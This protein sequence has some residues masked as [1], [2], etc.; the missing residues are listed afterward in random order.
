MKTI[1]IIVVDI[2]NAILNEHMEEEEEEEEDRRNASCDCNLQGYSRSSWN[3]WLH[4]LASSSCDCKGYKR[5]CHYQA[6]GAGHWELVSEIVWVEYFAFW[7]YKSLLVFYF[8][9]QTFLFCFFFGLTLLFIMANIHPFYHFLWFLFRKFC[10]GWS[11]VGVGLSNSCLFFLYI[12]LEPEIMKINQKYAIL[13]QPFVSIL[14]IF[15]YIKIL[16]IF[17]F[18]LHNYNVHHFMQWKKSPS[19]YITAYCVSNPRD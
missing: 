8:I 12:T 7:N 16:D 3:P 6:T 9:E 2:W 19:F 1:I 4:L 14:F 18:F 13:I 11:M 10:L 15:F 5:W 17:F